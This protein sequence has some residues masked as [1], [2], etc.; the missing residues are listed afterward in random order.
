MFLRFSLPFYL[1]LCY[2]NTM[3]WINSALPG[4]KFRPEKSA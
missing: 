4:S 1:F 3:Q 2:E